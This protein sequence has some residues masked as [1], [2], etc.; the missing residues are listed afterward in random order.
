VTRIGRMVKARS[1]QPV[2]TLITAQGP[3]PLDARGWEHF[4]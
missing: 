3:R 4:S 2:V 1:G